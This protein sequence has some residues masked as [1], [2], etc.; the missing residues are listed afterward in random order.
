[1][2]VRDREQLD[3]VPLHL[4][5]EIAALADELTLER[6]SWTLRPRKRR[7]RSHGH[8]VGPC[9][10]APEIGTGVAP[11][12]DQDSVTNATLL[13]LELDPVGPDGVALRK[14]VIQHARIALREQ[15]RLESR[16][17]ELVLEPQMIVRVLADRCDVPEAGTCA[18]GVP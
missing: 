13:E 15:S 7:L 3:G 9:R 4:L 5:L 10:R 1:R 11:R 6:L 8:L 14:H 12:V 16:V 17:P 18:P 2:L